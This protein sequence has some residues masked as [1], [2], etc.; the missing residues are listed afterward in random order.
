MCAQPVSCL[1]ESAWLPVFERKQGKNK[2]K[3]ETEK[4]SRMVHF[5]NTEPPLVVQPQNVRPHD[6]SFF[7]R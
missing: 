6:T 3:L 4:E 1:L 7:K 5:E 2:L